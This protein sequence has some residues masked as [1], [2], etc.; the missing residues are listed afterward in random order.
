MQK[1][2]FGFFHFLVYGLLEEAACVY[3][4]VSFEPFGLIRADGQGDMREIGG[5]DYATVLISY[6]TPL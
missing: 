5:H 2:L 1:E 4:W 6:W 3:G